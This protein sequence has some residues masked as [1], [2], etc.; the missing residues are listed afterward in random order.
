M[1]LSDIAFTPSV[2]A[3]QARFGSRA[4]YA[5]MEQ[6]GGWATTVT[7]DLA[8]FLG[9]A[10]SIYLATANASGQPYIQ[11]RGG[12]P[13]FLRPVDERTLG[14]ADFSGNRQY[15]SL[16]NLAEN[17]RAYIF[18]MDYAHRQRIKLWGEARVVED[19]AHLVA[20]LMPDGYKAR[21]ERA[22]LFRIE[23]WDANCRQHIPVLLP[24]EPVAQAIEGFEARIADLEAEI[25]KLR[26]E[27][28]A[29]L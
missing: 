5:R 11:H 21:A 8:A 4:A 7:P 20:R 16:G 13:G 27:R 17:P 2:K 24:A 29:F 22:I 10:R 26:E 28:R 1:A 14:F 15:I 19:D 3:I 6:N 18:I 25:A 9:A 12:P 23:A